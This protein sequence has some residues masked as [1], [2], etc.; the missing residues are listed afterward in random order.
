[1]IEPDP[2][3]VG[4]RQIDYHECVP[5]SLASALQSCG[6]GEQVQDIVNW[7]TAQGFDTTSGVT[8][9]HAAAYIAALGLAYDWDDGNVAMSEYVPAALAAGYPVLGFHQ[10]DG[11]A[12]PVPVGTPGAVEHC[13]L[14]YGDD[15]GSYQTM[16]PW[17]PNLES[18]AMATMDAADVRVHLTINLAVVGG[19][20]PKLKEDNMLR[21][22]V[23]NTGLGMYLVDSDG[24]YVGVSQ[25]TAPVEGIPAA[26]FNTWT[27]ARK[28]LFDKLVA[29]GQIPGLD[30]VAL[31]A[32][33]AS[34]V[35]CDGSTITCTGGDA[36]TN[37]SDDDYNNFVGHRA[38]NWPK[39][40]A[41]L[42]SGG[43]SSG[44]YAAVDHK[45]TSPSSTTSVPV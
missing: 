42:P 35:E 14:F 19:L 11:N 13:R 8:I 37:V 10:C 24:F 26:D 7:L 31:H 25:S 1:M 27:T 29:K 6:R 18:V 3:V 43:S 39:I 15:N 34:L 2:P 28:A 32:A 36:L 20:T 45:H 9:E 38:S 41:A 44:S 23:V 30:T 40:L 33:G 12:N 17:P 5:A 22:M 21:T 4:E 16:N